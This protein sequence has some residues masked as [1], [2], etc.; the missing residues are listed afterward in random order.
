M[1]VSVG[2]MC[3]NPSLRI[4]RIGKNKNKTVQGVN[5]LFLLLV[6]EVPEN[7]KRIQDIAIALGYSLKLDSK[8]LLLKI[9]HRLVTGHRKINQVLT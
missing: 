1:C 4:Q 7:P 9:S 3:V 8:T 5:Y 6:K 2:D